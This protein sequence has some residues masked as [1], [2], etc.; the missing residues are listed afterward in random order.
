MLNPSSCPDFQSQ[1]TSA[2]FFGSASRGTVEVQGGFDPTLDKNPVQGCHTRKG[3]ELLYVIK[4]RGT[5]DGCWI[6][7]VGRVPCQSTS[8]PI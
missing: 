1:A 6:L 2:F 5:L 7:E 8:Y 4:T 3:T